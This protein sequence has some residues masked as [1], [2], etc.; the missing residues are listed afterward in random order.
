MMTCAIEYYVICDTL[1]IS[2]NVAKS[3]FRN[4]YLNVNRTKLTCRVLSLNY[5]P[6]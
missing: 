3:F 1:K 2:L 6:W 5:L 4:L